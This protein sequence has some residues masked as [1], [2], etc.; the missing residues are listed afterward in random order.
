[1]KKVFALGLIVVT[2]AMLLVGCDS[3]V[4]DD[5]DE[6]FSGP[7]YYGIDGSEYLCK[8]CAKEYWAPL[9]YKNFKR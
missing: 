7:A 8:D 6:S 2:M 5:C 3:K 1:M 9:D 4:C